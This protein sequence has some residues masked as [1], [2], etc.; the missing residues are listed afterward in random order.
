MASLTD[1]SCTRADAVAGLAF[2]VLIMT[3]GH[4]STT[5]IREL[6]GK[7]KGLLL[8]GLKRHTM[9]W[10]LRE[11]EEAWTWG[12]AFIRVEGGIPGV[13]RVHYW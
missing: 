13:L 8:S 7:K 9:R 2:V 5:T 10:R 11:M 6:W 12:S 3:V 1:I 4:T